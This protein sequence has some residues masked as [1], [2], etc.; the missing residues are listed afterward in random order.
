MTTLMWTGSHSRAGSTWRPTYSPPT[1]LLCQKSF[2][3]RHH[4]ERAAHANQ[5]LRGSDRPPPKSLT[6]GL[7]SYG[8]CL[9]QMRLKGTATA[10]R[11]AGL[12]ELSGSHGLYVRHVGVFG[13]LLLWPAI[14]L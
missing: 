1:G 4:S 7:R 6:F 14:L 11:R 8:P 12:H 2:S 5:Q 9:R 13:L 10:Q 3:C